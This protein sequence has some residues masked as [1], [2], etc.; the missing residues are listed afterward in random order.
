MRRTIALCCLMALTLCGCATWVAVG[1]TYRESSRNYEVD[2]PHGWRKY[3][4][5]KDALLITRDGL[6]L[7]FIRIS[8]VALDKEMPHTKKKFSK[9]MLPQ[10]AAEV[11]TD[12]FLSAP[13][14]M[15]QDVLA[16][17]PADIDGH[18]GFRVEFTYKTKNG[19][20]KNAI[21]YGFLTGEWY[22]ELRYDPPKR[23]Y[24]K[25]DLS[26]FEEVKQSFRLM[27]TAT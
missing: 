5:S 6:S 16:N 20:T 14:I 2:L 21:V 19:L 25:K 27:K 3:N 26:T 10:E 22:C 23:H 15:A 7:Q 13:N 12:N 11:V 18:P 9:G 8:R 1:G 4:V 17:A 24:F